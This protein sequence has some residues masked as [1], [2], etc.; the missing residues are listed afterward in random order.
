MM[1]IFP[2]FFPVLNSS[3]NSSAGAHLKRTCEF[4]DRD[5]SEPNRKHVK[6]APKA[7]ILG[8]KSASRL[9]KGNTSMNA[10]VA[11]TPSL[12]TTDLQHQLSRIRFDSGIDL[13]CS[14]DISSCSDSQGSQE[15]HVKQGLPQ[16]KLYRCKRPRKA[17]VVVRKDCDE[18]EA[19]SHASAEG[20]AAAAK[21][22]GTKLLGNYE[23]EDNPVLLTFNDSALSES[24]INDILASIEKDF[25]SPM[26][27][28]LKTPPKPE[29]KTKLTST[30]LDDV[31]PN[32]PD[33]I[34][35]IRGVTPPSSD[36][37]QLDS[38]FFTPEGKL[39]TSTPYRGSSSSHSS[40]G[41][42]QKSPCLGSLRE[43]GL[44][45]LTPLKSPRKRAPIV[46][47]LGASPQFSLRELGLPG[48]TPLKT[49]RRSEQISDGVSLQ[50]SPNHSLSF[51]N[52]S[53]QKLLGD[54][55]LDS[56]MEDGVDIGNLSFLQSDGSPL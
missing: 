56:M 45:G 37:S 8:D 9:L 17:K 3:H 7:S 18:V 15:R 12:D 31:A 40:R 6:I 44:P 49:P 24:G 41:S 48:L 21:L 35:P 43:L 13:R 26:R 47:S 34:S 2:L 19:E 25:T 55:H 53:F 1:F 36:S 32:T 33:W 5:V 20:N 38:G 14:S 11:S 23:A 46:G 42:G 27:G 30:P 52:Q 28:L 39:A 51:S 54:I 4:P 29:E 16:P 50:C 10:S 22:C